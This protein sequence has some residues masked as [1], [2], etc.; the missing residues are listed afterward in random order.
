MTV[1]GI[2]SP[3]FFGNT[4]FKQKKMYGFLKETF[5]DFEPEEK[6]QVIQALSHEAE[7]KSQQDADTSDTANITAGKTSIGDNC[8]GCHA[9][10]DKGRG[11]EGKG[12]DL[13][14]TA[15]ASGS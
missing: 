2:S 15:A 7:L 9:F 14:A 8:T 5:A 12:P 6:Q 11:D 1:K 4:K 3:K 10:Q 13:P